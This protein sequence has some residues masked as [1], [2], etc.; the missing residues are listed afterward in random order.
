MDAVWVPAW[1][2]DN[3]F[4]CQTERSVER[5]AIFETPCQT[6]TVRITMPLF[7]KVNPSGAARL[8]R[9][10]AHDAFWVFFRLASLWAECFAGFE[11]HWIVVALW[12]PDELAQR[13]LPRFEQSGIFRVVADRRCT[14]LNMRRA[15]SS[16]V[17]IGNHRLISYNNYLIQL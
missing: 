7:P 13:P 9:W 12:W 16:R 10:P 11:L 2:P 1:L 8:A 14:R 17:R 4:C 15:T 5:S 3:E 6:L